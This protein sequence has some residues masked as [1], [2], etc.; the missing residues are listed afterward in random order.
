MSNDASFKNVV[1]SANKMCEW[2]LRLRTFTT[3]EPSLML[4]YSP[5]WIIAVSYGAQ[6]KL[7][8]YRH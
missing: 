4:T 3:R 2:I 1:D 5:D 8:M 6:S 7:E